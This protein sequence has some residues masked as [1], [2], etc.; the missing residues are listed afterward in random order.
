[1]KTVAINDENQGREVV[2]SRSA[3]G[4]VTPTAPIWTGGRVRPGALRSRH[5]SGRSAD[6]R[7]EAVSG[8]QRLF[9]SVS[10]HVSKSNAVIAMSPA[11]RAAA[12]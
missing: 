5:R 11:S 6:D 10:G 12:T 2:G 8:I 4:T 9:P 3:S 1:M 7:T